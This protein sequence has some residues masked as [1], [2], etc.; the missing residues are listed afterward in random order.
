MY[1][2]RFFFVI[3]FI[4]QMMSPIHGSLLEEIANLQPADNKELPTPNPVALHPQWWHYFHVDGE[5]LKKRIQATNRL[6]QEVYTTLPIEEQGVAYPLIEKISNTLNALPFAKLQQN[7]SSQTESHPFL[8]SY[9]LE[10][11]LELY[12]QIRKLKAEIKSENDHFKEAKNRLAKVQKNSDNLMVAYLGQTQPSTKKLLNGLEIMNYQTN[13]ALGI[14]NLKVVAHRVEEMTHRLSK[15][16]E[17]LTYSNDR[18][19][20][21]EFDLAA[22]EN[23]ML[24]HEKDLEHSQKKLAI[25][26][27]NLIGVFNDS[28]NDRNHH[29][30]LEQQLLQATVSRAHDWAK[31]AFHTFKYNLIMHMNGNFEEEND[32]RH[33]LEK[34]KEEISSISHQVHD[35]KKSALK[36]QDRIRHEYTALVAQEK[37]D[38][39]LLKNNQ[40]Q[41]QANL[42]ILAVVELLEE[43]ISHTDWLIN[44]LDIHFK[45][46]SSLLMNWWIDFYNFTTKT[47]ANLMLT[48]NYSLFKVKGVPITLWGIFK[49][50]AIILISYW[51]SRVVRSALISFGRRRGDMNEATLYTLGGL[52]RYL[53]LLLGLIVA[54]CSIGLDMNSLVFIAGAL[55]FGISF[56]LQSIA[57]NFFCGLRI[58]F[59]GKLKIGDYIELHSGHKGKVCEIHIQ[60]TVVNTNDGQRVIVPNSE[61]ISNTLVNWAKQSID[62]RRL[63]IPFAV[64][65]ESDKELV[66]RVVVEAAKRVPCLLKDPEY[67][68]PQVWLVNFDSYGLYFELVVWINYKAE[69]FSDSKEAD[70]LWEIE[71][72]LRESSIKPPTNLLD[73]FP[74]REVKTEGPHAA[75]QTQHH[76][77]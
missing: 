46:N 16:E 66:R 10:K 61:L 11:Q 22:L 41:R 2:C 19:D 23:N 38:S 48:M 25:A 30:L 1:L 27:T 54:L 43:E 40:M 26:E 62:Y 18:L 24:I 76:S 31:L 57:N 67:S 56:G 33:N 75:V 70:F 59:E 17:E 68:E 34:W 51:I 49:I 3:L 37:Q 5:E 72:A 4:F 73:L 44:L 63:H 14:E 13:I 53:I 28:N 47:W 20:V 77:H 50:I 74:V 39:K 7:H 58:L 64:A 29:H 35:W 42:N 71:T 32:F 12:K 69:A 15:L 6:L 36:E 45:K 65:A 8:K 55:M 60:N 52:A 21:K 9:S